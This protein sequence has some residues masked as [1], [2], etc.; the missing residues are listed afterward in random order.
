MKKPIIPI[1]LA[2]GVVLSGTLTSQIAF[3]EDSVVLAKK[4]LNRPYQWG[5]NDCSG[6]TKKVFGKL[7]IDLPH[8]SVQQARFGTRVSKSNLKP[9]DLVFFNTSGEGISH[10]GIYVG[11]GWMI[12]SENKKT[13]VRETQIFGA[14]P[15]SY[16]EPRFVTGRRLQRKAFGSV[17]TYV[18]AKA[19]NT[20]L[21]LSAKK[22]EQSLGN[23]LERSHAKSMNDTIY[24]VKT[25][26][27]LS[28]I[29]QHVS[30]PI[31]ELKAL[32]QLSSDLII[33]GQ[34]LRYKAPHDTPKFPFSEKDSA[35]NNKAMEDQSDERI[36]SRNA[37]AFWS[38]LAR[39][40]IFLTK[41]QKINQKET[42]RIFP[43]QKL[44]LQ[45]EA[46]GNN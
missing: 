35:M 16:W 14:G 27:T 5:Q 18:H 30:V 3:A 33:P 44:Y 42:I 13:G 20:S 9:G 6:F 45:Y 29:S 4:E 43:G 23:L 15:A 31:S 10:V 32:N 22:S 34:K 37:D 1:A 36:K 2:S 21:D 8:S 39:H 41:F 40:G 24:T 46:M 7:G 11:G 28:E 26:D 38:I 12:S 19:D 25:G 17:K